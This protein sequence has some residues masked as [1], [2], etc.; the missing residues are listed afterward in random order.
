[1]F[2]FQ[3]MLGLLGLL[4]RLPRGLL[5]GLVLFLFGLVLVE[6]VHPSP[7]HVPLRA[8]VTRLRASPPPAT[9]HVPR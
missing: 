2:L 5:L 1:M 9:S 7:R 6:L 8:A 3:I 4:L